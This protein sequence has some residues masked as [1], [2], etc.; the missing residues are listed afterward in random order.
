MFAF[1]IGSNDW[2]RHSAYCAQGPMTIQMMA[3]HPV[4]GATLLLANRGQ[5]RL[6]HA[7]SLDFSYLAL[8]PQGPTSLQLKSINFKGKEKVQRL[9]RM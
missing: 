6:L 1:L 7:R 5:G 8:S 2:L 3:L 4:V 9:G